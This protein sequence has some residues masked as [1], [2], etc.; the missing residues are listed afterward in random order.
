MTLLTVDTSALS[1]D[2]TVGTL[3]AH[4]FTSDASMI[5]QV[6]ELAPV[7][8]HV[9][10]N[11]KTEI[12]SRFL[13]DPRIRWPD[14][15]AA[16]QN[17]PTAS[18][19]AILAA[20]VLFDE[21]PSPSIRHQLS[22]IKSIGLFTFA[23]SYAD[24]SNSALL[25]SLAVHAL[26][27]ELVEVP[28]GP[29]VYGATP[30]ELEAEYRLLYRI[31]ETTAA[32]MEAWLGFNHTRRVLE[33]ERYFIS[34]GPVTR[35]LY[36]EYTGVQV[37]A[38]MEEH[39]AVQITWDEARRFAEWACCRLPTEIEWEKA[40][41]GTDGRTYSWGNTPDLSRCNVVQSNHN[42]TTPVGYYQNHS[43][44]GC[45]D[46][47]GNVWE[48]TGSSYSEMNPK[49][50]IR[51]GSWVCSMEFA[52]CTSRCWDAPDDRSVAVGFRLVLS[53]PHV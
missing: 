18:L 26:M 22:D 17:Y 36:A 2:E 53:D 21:N 44:F 23:N 1:L 20:A 42:G 12:T 31:R 25:R 50:V 41:R 29:F 11:H 34:R 52:R 24:R 8:L 30:E 47:N 19:R 37:P 51:G 15:V 7:V 5:L 13:A 45:L 16:A 9:I 35:R 43:P 14:L 40:V 27:R 49:K 32:N 46:G 6:S 10:S 28:A 48:W 3:L 33:T 39:P 38:E 4:R